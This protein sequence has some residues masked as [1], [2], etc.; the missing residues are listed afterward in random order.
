MLPSTLQGAKVQVCEFQVAITLRPGEGTPTSSSG[1]LD[2]GAIAGIVL[3]GLLAAALLALAAGYWLWR[4]RWLS[5]QSKMAALGAA[6]KGFDQAEW[7]R[8]HAH[9]IDG[10]SS[11]AQ[12]L[13]KRS[14]DGSGA[15]AAAVPA[16][17]LQAGGSGGSGGEEIEDLEAAKS[18]GKGDHQALQGAANGSG[19]NNA[20]QKA[21]AATSELQLIRQFFRAVSWG[22][23]T[24]ILDTAALFTTACLP[25]SWGSFCLHT[26]LRT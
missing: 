18:G 8:Q 9:E 19:G 22:M 10:G 12:T 25:D 24:C 23:Y 2:P 13:P 15:A 21:V 4:R 16:A 3:G 17:D 20:G 26:G 7:D 6:D 1:G 5:H 11:S 14:V